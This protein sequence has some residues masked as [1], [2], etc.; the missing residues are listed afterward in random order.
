MIR[1]WVT[2]KMNGALSAYQRK[3]PFP[4]GSKA[5]DIWRQMHKHSYPRILRTWDRAKKGTEQLRISQFM[6][7]PKP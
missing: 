2:E 4:A 3:C 6:Q 7:E 5:A 1:L